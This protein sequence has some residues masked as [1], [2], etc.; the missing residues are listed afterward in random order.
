M[1]TKIQEFN[2]RPKVVDG[3][4]QGQIIE[5]CCPNCDGKL[6]P[7]RGGDP[8]GARGAR[9]RWDFSCHCGSWTHE[10]ENSRPVVSDWTYRPVQW[11]NPR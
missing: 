5:Y 10:T 8:R 2:V 7:L 11:G 9:L 4:E 1:S 6:I 3:I